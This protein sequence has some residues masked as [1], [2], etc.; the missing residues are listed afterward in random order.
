M[1]ILVDLGQFKDETSLNSIQVL[2]VFRCQN[3]KQNIEPA[4]HAISV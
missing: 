2:K 4:L 3:S 1:H